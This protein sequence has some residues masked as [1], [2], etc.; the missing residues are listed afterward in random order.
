M[1]FKLIVVILWSRRVMAGLTCACISISM[2]VLIG[3]D[4]LRL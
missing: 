4:H 3:V 2:L 1:L